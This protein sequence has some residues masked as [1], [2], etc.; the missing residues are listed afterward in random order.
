M[1][2]GKNRI[3]GN[4]YKKGAEKHPFCRPFVSFPKVWKD[5]QP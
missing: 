4:E 1:D 2:T 3:V 5:W